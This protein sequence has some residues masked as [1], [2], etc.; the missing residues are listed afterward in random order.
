MLRIKQ[1]VAARAREQSLRAALAAFAGAPG[2]EECAGAARA[3]F[4]QEVPEA[5]LMKEELWT[6]AVE[7]EGGGDH[8]P[9]HLFCK[10]SAQLDVDA[11]LAHLCGLHAKVL[12]LLALR[13]QKYKY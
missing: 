13:V 12:S 4:V 10:S 3:R 9:R 5:E 2:G 6:L 1:V 11:F 7:S 8:A